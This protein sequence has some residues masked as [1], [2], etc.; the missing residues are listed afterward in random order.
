VRIWRLHNPHDHHYLGAGRRGA[1]APS[2][3]LCPECTAPSQRRAQPLR[4]AWDRSK[5]TAV[6]DFTWPGF[7]T[8][9]VITERVLAGLRRFTGFELGPVEVVQQRGAAKPKD[10]PPLH[11][12]WITT[13]V[14]PDYERS[15]IELERRRRTCGIER[16]ALYGVERWDSHYDAQA[17]ELVREHSDR[18]PGAGIFVAGTQLAGAAIFRARGFG[19]IFCTDDVKSTIER[20]GYSNVAFLEMGD[21]VP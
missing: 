8:E 16:W 6:G 7:D 3:G 2:T 9:V 19:W 5:A 4:M 18:L 13:T 21:T 14:S 10:V 17:G 11:E 1:W 20:E 15:S 12:L